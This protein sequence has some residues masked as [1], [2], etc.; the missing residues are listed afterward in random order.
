MKRLVVLSVLL[1]GLGGVFAQQW[2]QVGVLALDAE[3]GETVLI[4]EW[5]FPGTVR[6]S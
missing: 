6:P 3:G 2:Q 5:V 1:M 4:V